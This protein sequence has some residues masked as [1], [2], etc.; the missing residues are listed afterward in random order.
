MVRKRVPSLLNPRGRANDGNEKLS[1]KPRCVFFSILIGLMMY[2]GALP[3]L[4]K[5]AKASEAR[6]LDGDNLSLVSTVTALR[7]GRGGNALSLS[8]TPAL[9]GAERGTVKCDV[10]VDS[11]AY[12][13][14]P[15][16]L[17]DRLF[18]SPFAGKERDGKPRY[19]TFEP[20]RGG[21]NNLRMSFENVVVI[22]A[23]TGRTLVLPPD[24]PLYLLQNDPQHVERN[25]GDFFN[26][27]TP[28][29]SSRITVITTEEFISR[30]GSKD[31]RFTIPDSMKDGVANAQKKCQHRKKSDI[32]CMFVYDY[33]KEI[34][35]SPS[36]HGEQSC[37]IFDEGRLNSKPMDQQKLDDDRVKKFC[38][39]RRA[40][41]YDK[42]FRDAPVVHLRASER[43]FR[44]L[45]HFY[46]FILFTDPVHDN[47]FKRFIRDHIHYNDAII[48]AAGKIVDALQ[49]EGLSRGFVRDE[50][51]AGGF[52]S[53]H[54]RR[55]DFQ[56][57]NTR[58]SAEEWQ[59]NTRDLW[60][61]NE[62][63]YVTSDEKNRSFFEPIAA[64]HDL[65]FIEDFF[66]TAGLKDVDPNYIGMIE[67]V[68]A[69]RGKQ[70]CGTYFSSFTAYIGRLRGYYGMSEKTM[71]YGQ[72]GRH[73][74]THVWVDPQSSYSAREFP[75]GW[76]GI[77][78]DEEVSGFLK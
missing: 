2:V 32:A 45:C 18:Q 38:Q 36:I 78:G 60:R 71:W 50:E 1:V 13:N 43:G 29:F 19:L 55:G 68:V 15:Q 4:L 67:S 3:L 22:A 30:E 44:L 24:Q 26:L 31:G 23:A 10:N 33:L 56:W 6:H 58:L 52:S 49:R 54:V 28:E 51:G 72:E 16:G 74:E 11:L 65:R 7:I 73:A 47:F 21:W 12:W 25:F 62:I 75:V 5:S 46:A 14:S 57:K 8:K 70:F 37:L 63:L 77:D 35:F 76:V 9:K 61:E 59:K 66:D 53:M 39:G 42:E 17:R 64:H 20:D 48:C 69:S 34:S 40:V 41:Y 27:Y